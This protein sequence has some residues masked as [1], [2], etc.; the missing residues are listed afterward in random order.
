MG[1]ILQSNHI[2]SNSQASSDADDE[3]EMLKYQ[4]Q[5]NNAFSINEIQRLYT[6]W[7]KWYPTGKAQK[8]NFC[9]FLKSEPG[10]SSPEIIVDDLFRAMDTNKDGFVNFEEYLIFMSITRPTAKESD[11][12][13]LIRFFFQIYDK[14][15]I[16]KVTKEN[17]ME[18]TA[19]AFKAR[20][21][22]VNDPNIKQIIEENATKLM[23][24]ADSNNDNLLTVDEILQAYQ[25]NHSV[26]RYL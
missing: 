6:Q 8:N 22:D 2:S 23:E 16:G 20:G 15:N 14:D 5:V 4:K 17:I 1:Q 11:P 12:E 3:I 21:N 25:K 9:E 10:I 13:Q 7:Y 19:H 18:C 26:L 24:M